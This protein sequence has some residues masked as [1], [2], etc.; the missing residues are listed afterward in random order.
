MARDTAEIRRARIITDIIIHTILTGSQ[1][2][3]HL[4][5]TAP[6]H[7]L[8]EGTLAEAVADIQAEYLAAAARAVRLVAAEGDR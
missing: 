8:P 6:R 5:H 1:I 7:I 4:R 3:L 2:I